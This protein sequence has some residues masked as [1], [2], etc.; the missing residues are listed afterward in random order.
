MKAR[1]YYEADDWLTCAEPQREPSALATQVKSG[2]SIY[3]VRFC[4]GSFPED[5]GNPRITASTGTTMDP[6]GDTTICPSASSK[7]I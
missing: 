7:T 4:V 6:T 1:I 3:M 5:H 2:R